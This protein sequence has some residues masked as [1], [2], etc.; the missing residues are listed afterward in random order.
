M[1]AASMVNAAV[2]A[3]TNP[4]PIQPGI[5]WSVSRSTASFVFFAF[6]QVAGWVFAAHR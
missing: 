5:N 3:V 4:S 2:C 1:A 6:S